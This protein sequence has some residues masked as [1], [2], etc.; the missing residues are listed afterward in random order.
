M[1]L[2]LPKKQKKTQPTDV[3]KTSSLVL[4]GEKRVS[5]V[6]LEQK[7]KKEA[8]NQ[9]AVDKDLY[10]QMR[11]RGNN[12]I[13]IQRGL[14]P[15][16]VSKAKEGA[17]A[18]GKVLGGFFGQMS[19][20]VKAGFDV[21]GGVLAAGIQAKTGALGQGVS[22]RDYAK[23]G[24]EEAKKTITT[25]GA[26][27]IGTALFQGIRFGTRAAA[28]PVAAGFASVPG[29]VTPKQ[30]FFEGID[31]AKQVATEKDSYEEDWQKM[32][33]MYLEKRKL[34]PYGTNEPT[35]ADVAALAGLQF[36]NLTGDL[37][38]GAILSLIHI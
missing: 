24:V 25:P 6:R 17:K 21:T 2:I 23:I 3:K 33:D 31:R 27:G 8:T 12:A 36:L 16:K 19:R 22:P 5:E 38:V 18:V 32:S 29:G 37:G 7:Y 20:N 14:E 4:P 35:T 15:E 11:K 10:V 34:G 30:A 26:P 28:A 13:D 1:A 9:T